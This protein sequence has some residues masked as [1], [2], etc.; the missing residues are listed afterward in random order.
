[1]EQDTPTGGHARKLRPGFPFRALL[2]CAFA[3]LAFCAGAPAA[4]AGQPLAEADGLRAQVVRLHGEGRYREAIPLAQ[5]DLAIRE[6]T[7]GPA[8]PNLTAS[9]L[10]LAELY[11]QV[12]AYPQAAPL[13]RRALDIQARILGPEH[14]DTV[15]TMNQ[16]GALYLDLGEY[17]NA[18]P[19]L[20]RVVQ[21]SEKVHGPS[22]PK[23]AGSLNNLADLYRRAGDSPRAEPLFKRALAIAEKSL[24][25]EHPHTL[26]F[27]NNLAV[28][29]E[30]SGEYAK[31]EPLLTRALAAREKIAGPW[32]R[33]TAVSLTNLAALY[34]TLGDFA[35]A[36]PLYRRAL[37]ID[38]RV[39]GPEHPNTAIDLNNLG[40]LYEALGDYARAEPLFKRSLAIREKVLGPG[41]PATATCL[42]NLAA[43]YKAMGDDAKA[44]PLYQ[45]AFALSEKVLGPGHPDTVLHMVNL[46]LMYFSDGD[47]ARAEPLL[48]RALSFRERTFGD[49]HPDT[50]NTLNNLASLYVATG[51]PAAARQLFRR[52]QEAS[53]A[54]AEQIMGF[55]TED[56]STL[57]L[58]TQRNG[59]EG[60]LSLVDRQMSGD[61]GAVRDGLTAWLRYK[62]VLLDAQK[63]FQEALLRSDDPKVAALAREFAQVR[64]RLSALAFA[65]PGK[66]GAEA[67]RRQIAELEA[68]RQRLE[69]D[70]SARSQSFASSRR[71]YRADAAA[72]AKALPREAVLVEYARVSLF[73]FKAKDKGKRWDP[74]HYLAFVLRPGSEGQAALVDLGEAGPI[75]DLV[76]AMGKEMRESQASK[77]PA[78][79]ARAKL[80]VRLHDRVFAPLRQAV[81]AGK[82]IFLS[83]DGSLNLV[84]FETLQNAAGRFLVDDYAFTYLNSGRDLTGFGLKATPKN[85]VLLLGDPDF[86]LTPAKRE[87][88]LHELRLSRGRPAGQVFL[89]SAARRGG[90]YPPL[91][92]TRQEVQAIAALLGRDCEVFL[93]GKAL[94]EVLFAK[95]APRE[96]HLATHG[97]FYTEQEFAHAFADAGAG[98]SGPGAAAPAARPEN[99]LL[100]SGV[101]LAG[102][103]ASLKSGNP[104]DN[105]GILTADKVLSLD[106]HGTDLVVLSACD[107]GSGEVKA[108]QG[109]YGLRR[110][111][112]AAGAKGVVMSMWSVPDKE[113]R[114]LMVEFHK[115]LLSGRLDRARALR[116]A[117]L[118]EKDV[119][120]ERYGNANPLYW[121]AF[122]FA[123]ER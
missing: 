41:H 91:P 80:A 109:V 90:D 18:E 101:V 59:L 25:P 108:G 75:D 121:G 45:K 27:L 12:A 38:A 57:F 16:L 123:G 8:H 64:T 68:R 83:P 15:F 118:R 96:L 100:R 107:T 120:R 87:Q 74:P 62:G 22:D 88:A 72:V 93:G 20:Q 112:N 46:A 44:R 105:D 65:G 92:E 35:R 67:Y 63:R 32:H 115:G 58:E 113:T 76:A 54:L 97:F 78:G 110:A 60:F 11:S 50:I 28:T 36:E 23:T 73:N 7:F 53:G 9:L 84:P 4:W 56:R 51:R 114:E 24:G 77:D 31:A 103:N 82:D 52:A 111:F 95:P 117:M 79:I 89:R 2:A 70:L 43:L 1:M 86:D 98:L 34:K 10:N 5:R 61:P 85:K 42:N 21:H 106:L 33:D 48:K 26:L 3:A 39:L 30:Q 6:K 66:A 119:V 99:P 116:Q 104:R 49:I 17:A 55:A 19:L 71:Q 40:T 94:E 29:Y 69:A 102:A 122:V 81:G 37:D 47:A 14:Q 13:Y